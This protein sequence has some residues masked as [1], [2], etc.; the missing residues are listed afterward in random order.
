MHSVPRLAAAVA[1]LL[2]VV[3]GARAELGSGSEAERYRF[4][5]HP[6]IQVA[7][8]ADSNVLLEDDDP[9]RDLGVFILPRVELGFHGR[10]FDLGADLGADVR[11]YVDSDSPSDEFFRLSGFAE[12]G[13]LPGLTF[14]ASNAYTPTPVYL[15]RPE[16]HSANLVQTNRTVAGLRY[17]R[18]LP[19]GSEMLLALEGTRLSSEG[20]AA[21]VE[22][23]VIDDDFHADLWEGAILWEFQSILFGSTSAFVRT[24]A[25]FRSF[26]DSSVSDFGDFTLLVGVRTHW[27][28]SLDFDAAGGYGLLAFESESKNRFLGQA[29]L[30][31]RIPDGTILRLSF[32]NRNTAD[33]VGNDFVEMT[34]KIGLE[35]RFGERT[36][37]SV[38][39]L[40][41]RFENEVWDSGSNLF[42]GVEA[43]IR[44]QL[45]RRTQLGLIY[46]HWYNGGGYGVDDFSQ[47][48]VS[49]VFS[50]RH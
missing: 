5:F 9:E 42:W 14:R 45:T 34:G 26:D 38:D 39:L 31:Y 3:S 17:W 30:R 28:G 35:R 19:L 46:R 23:G 48:R 50:Y 44:R 43:R 36:A 29:N 27:F 41:S 1:I 22:N 25:R 20:F 11:R 24:N 37:A 40:L 47:D 15:G 21:E 4:S 6:S 16:D 18:E 49:L 33:I 7:A 10:W 2:L 12:F 32:V 8:T 13:L